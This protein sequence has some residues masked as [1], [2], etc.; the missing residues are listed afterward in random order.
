M[1]EGDPFERVQRVVQDELETLRLRL[2]STDSTLTG[3][4]DTAKQKIG[5]QVEALKGKYVSAAARRDETVLRHLETL[6][7]SLFPDKKPQERV[8]NVASFVARYGP[9]VVSTL[10]NRFRVERHDHQVVAI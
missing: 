9:G 3:A 10:T 7:N 8:L 2:S 4:L 5:H 6:S 1:D